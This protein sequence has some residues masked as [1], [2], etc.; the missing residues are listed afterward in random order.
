[1]KAELKKRIPSGLV[2]AG[3]LALIT[4]GAPAVS[5][6]LLHITVV[7]IALIEFY[8]MLSNQ[9]I[10]C[11]SI[12]GAVL[13]V[14]ITG[15]IWLSNMAF[16]PAW[17]RDIEVLTLACAVLVIGIRQF[18]QKN[19]VQPIATMA[20]TL[21][22]LLYIVVL[23]GFLAKL[24]LFD[25]GLNLLDKTTKCGRWLLWYT[26]CVA[27]ITDIGAYFA[28]SAFGKHK[29]FE[30]ISPSKTWEGVIG[31]VVCGVL[32]SAGFYFVSKN[33][34]ASSLNFSLF[35]ALLLG[36]LLPVAGILGDL[37][38]SLLK[39][40]AGKKDASSLIPGMGGLLDVLD[41]IFFAAPVAYLYFR[42]ITSL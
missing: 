5:V 26:V 2:L 23:F 18:P 33:T 22:G 30:R 20:G 36:I 10:P 15:G 21:F 25:G 24:L 17:T 19:N 6:A 28:G 1:V 40:S 12:F 37:F 13:G 41:S 31:G 14:I 29:L 27:K 35:D 42:I 38:E 32:M 4:F 9:N 3:L 7:I 8:H 34:F 16:A 39:R 11:F